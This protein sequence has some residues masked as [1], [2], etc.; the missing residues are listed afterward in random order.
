MY[1]FNY[2]TISDYTVYNPSIPFKLKFPGPDQCDGVKLLMIV[3]KIPESMV[4]VGQHFLF[5]SL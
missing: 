3:G 4:K 1:C 2:F 5:L